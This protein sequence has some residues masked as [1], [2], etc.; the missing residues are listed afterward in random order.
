MFNLIT[1][2]PDGTCTLTSIDHDKH[3]DCDG[4]IRVSIC[5][6][7]LDAMTELSRIALDHQLT[8]SRTIDAPAD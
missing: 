7:T 2:S 6:D 4:T 3:D 8:L 5:L 1:A